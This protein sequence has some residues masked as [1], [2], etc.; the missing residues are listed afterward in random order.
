MTIAAYPLS[1][2][3]TMPRRKVAREAGQFKTTLAGALE[4]CRKSLEAFGRD[5]RVAAAL[6]YCQRDADPS[7]GVRNVEPQP[8]Q[9]VWEHGEVVRLC[10]GAWRARYK[11]P[12]AV[13]AVAWDTSLPPVDMR[14]LRP[15]DRQGDTFSLERRAAIGTLSRRSLRALDGYLS[16][17]GADVASTAPIFRNRSG[18]AYS[19]DTLGDDFRDVRTLV[20]GLE[21]RRTHADFRRSGTVEAIRGGTE[22]GQIAAKMA[23]QFDKSAFLRKTYAPV[24]L[25]AVRAA[26]EARKRGR[27]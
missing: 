16:E 27:R 1:W 10:K 14:S 21:E 3:E 19:K 17:L 2:P 5:S 12:A 25:Q 15:I 8:R 20:F 13:M 4:N 24:D 6:K 7:L 26:D 22:G 18:R 23:N 9:A 11:G